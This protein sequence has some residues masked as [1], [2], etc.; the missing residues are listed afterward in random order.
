MKQDIRNRETGETMSR[1]S[2]KWENI[3]NEM[4]AS[5]EDPLKSKWWDKAWEIMLD[6]KLGPVVNSKMADVEVALLLME[7]RNIHTGYEFMYWEHDYD[8]MWLDYWDVTGVPWDKLTS[9]LNSQGFLENKDVA[10]PRDDDRQPVR[11]AIH[12]Y[13]WSKRQVIFDALLL[14]FEDEISLGMFMLGPKIPRNRDRA[15]R[16]IGYADNQ[17]EF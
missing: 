5:V 13:C 11:D 9:F 1:F 3:K 12:S 4:F 14:H 8:P 2:V 17:F 16:I 7:L 6:P 10:V 15:S